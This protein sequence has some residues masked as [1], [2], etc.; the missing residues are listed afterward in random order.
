[1][2]NA[3]MQDEKGITILIWASMG[4]NVEIV[5]AIL[6]AGADIDAIDR[7]SMICAPACMW[8]SSYFI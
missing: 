4:G 7:V 5:K 6:A 3:C 1:M 2:H 8:W